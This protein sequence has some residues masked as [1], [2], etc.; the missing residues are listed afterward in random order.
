MGAKPRTKLLAAA[1]AAC[2]LPLAP[3][4]EAGY[5]PGCRVRLDLGIGP[6][7]VARAMALQADGRIVVAGY[8]DFGVTKDFIVARFHPDLSLDTSFNGTGYV[9]QNFDTQDEAYGVA[10]QTDGKILVVGYAENF[11][12][13]R[14]YL[15]L[16]RYLPDGTLDTSFNAPFGLIMWDLFGGGG[17]KFEELR[18]VALQPDG[19]I[20][21][22]GYHTGGSIQRLYVA[23][24]LE[25][26]NFDASFAGGGDLN[27]TI[28]DFSI[29]SGV[30]I[31]PGVT[32][33]CRGRA[34]S[35]GTPTS[36]PCGCG[37][38]EAWMQV[39]TES[40]GWI[41]TSAPSTTT[42]PPWPWT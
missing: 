10:I 11:N 31:T 25:D 34:R 36:S 18:A 33:S 9:T 26:G 28:G 27:S 3:G 24:F 13:T 29:A 5:A 1:L 38:T 8:V 4:V 7:H 23:R 12:A 32:S 40:G 39:S 14:R 41:R 15:A 2:L 17:N 21:A 20:V 19:K 6:I 35:A 37:P 30:T 22:A 42:H 16:A